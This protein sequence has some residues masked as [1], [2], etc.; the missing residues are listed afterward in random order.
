[1][2]R[3]LGLFAGFAVL[4]LLLAACGGLAGEPP[5]VSTLS[6]PTAAPE[7][8]G[9]PVAPPDLAAGAQ[10]FA[11]N[12]TRCHGASGAGDG[13]LVASG[14]I[15]KI[16]S[17]RDPATSFGVAPKDWFSIVSDGKIANL[18]PPWRG[19]LDE[20]QRWAVTM[21]VYTLADTPDQLAAGATVY[22]AN[23]A[24]CHGDS[25]KGDGPKAKEITRPMPDF[26]S[27]VK[28]V[29]LSDSTIYNIATKG[30]GAQMPA[31]AD[32]LTD[33]QRRAVAAYV[34]TLSLGNASALRQPQPP[35]ATPEVTAPALAAP[36]TATISGRITNGT[37][38]AALPPNLPV[39]L[40]AITQTAQGF[41]N[42]PYSAVAGADGSYNVPNV[43]VDPTKSYIVSTLYRGRVFPGKLMTGDALA[44]DPNMPIT[45][46]ELTEDPTVVHIASMDF[47]VDAVGEGLQVLQDVVFKN[48]SDRMYTNSVAIDQNHYASVIVGLPPGAF[49]LAFPDASRYT[50]AQNNSVVVDSVPVLP[51]EDHDVQFSYFVPYTDGAVIEQS[52]YYITDAKVRLLLHPDAITATSKQLLPAGTETIQS[53][54]YQVYS[55]QL[56]LKPGD[57]IRYDLAGAPPSAA[58]V[59]AANSSQLPIILILGLVAEAM[60]V[61]ALFYL[62][63]RRR[64]PSA[65]SRQAVT[66]ALIRQIAELDNQHSA[67]TVEEADYQTRRAQLKARLAELMQ[68]DKK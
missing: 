42:Q 27:Q 52:V 3:L 32:K 67:G 5:I 65:P 36:I 37:A 33:D 13:E 8:V 45:I 34:R 59:A 60:I 48:T 25:G 28:L 56:V 54:I 12:C 38:G 19:M 26:T 62:Y 41:T 20:E 63:L 7:D 44:N 40:Y 23:C 11:A 46:Y 57:T 10:I 47:Q 61:G 24:E 6:P 1:M 50:L 64:K 9:H 31:F 43:V 58:T 55:G 68:P 30:Q 18:M 4:A 15:P 49:G 16:A 35:N 51:G 14:Q 66:D 2:R 17:F 53:L 29:S 21:Y 22:S 39:T